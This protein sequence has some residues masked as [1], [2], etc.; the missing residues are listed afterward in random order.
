M[1]LDKKWFWGIYSGLIVLLL[2][3]A[4][5]S[6]PDAEPVVIVAETATTRTI[7]HTFGTT[8][9]PAEPQRVVALGEE[10]LLA[11][12]LD[13]GIEPMVS[14]VN[15][16]EHVPLIS[17]EELANTE[18]VRTSTN[19][20]LETLV[21][22]DPDLIIGTVYFVDQAGYS[23]LAEIA[24]TVAVGGDNSLEVYVETLTV[25]GLRDQ[26][27]A[28]AATF[29]QLI[30]SE[31]ARISAADQAVSVVA[32]YGGPNVALFF[33]GPQPPPQMLHDMGVTMLPVGEERDKLRI[34]NGR[35]FISDERLDLISGEQMILLQTSSVEG[36]MESFA[37]ISE[38]PLWQ[39]LPAVQSDNIVVIDRIGYPGFRGQQALLADLV[40]AFEE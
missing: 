19:V 20:S 9:I 21:A 5:S 31:S 40:Q 1:S 11:D 13:I 6:A 15:V 37:E 33:D 16:P 35:A 10:G 27:E 30:A 22:Y 7:E 17:D 26:A 14:I 4:C 28:N 29:R 2:L 12:L 3:A 39:Q 38:D 32:V 8:E 34:R 36:E 18:L 24:P 23:R 25:F